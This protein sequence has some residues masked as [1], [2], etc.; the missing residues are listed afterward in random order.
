MLH[1]YLRT[2][3]FTCIFG[4][5]KIAG[6]FYLKKFVS[7]MSIISTVFRNQRAAEFLPVWSQILKY[8]IKYIN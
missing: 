6:N 7:P 2:L 1:K 5:F 4:D 8:H 3:F